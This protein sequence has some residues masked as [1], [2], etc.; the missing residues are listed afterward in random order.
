MSNQFETRNSDIGITIHLKMNGKLLENQMLLGR[1]LLIIFD[2][3]FVYLAYEAYTDKG[4]LSFFELIIFL[5]FLIY[6]LHIDYEHR[7]NNRWIKHADEVFIISKNKLS[8]SKKCF[9]QN[10]L[11]IDID[12][13]KINEISYNPW[14]GG[15]YPPLPA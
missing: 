8:I 11:T 5:A 14:L 3:L 15:R 7:K 10:L 13:Q 4:N 2:F 12:T 1:F 6:I 9:D